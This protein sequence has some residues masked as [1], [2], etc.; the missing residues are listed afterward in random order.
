MNPAPYKSGAPDAAATLTLAAAAGIRVLHHRL[1][2]VDQRDVLV[3]ERFDREPLK[4]VVCR[5]RCWVASRTLTSYPDLSEVLL[6]HAEDFVG[7]RKKLVRR[8]V[9]NILVGNE[10]DHAKNNRH[11]CLILRLLTSRKSLSGKRK[12]TR[13]D[14]R[15]SDDMWEFRFGFVYALLHKIDRN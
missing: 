11:A 15:V 14:Q 5:H 7:D 9:F 1:E 8:M 12:S 13:S 2:Q 3:V 4:G 10:D 6:R